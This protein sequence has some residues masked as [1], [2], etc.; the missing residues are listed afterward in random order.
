MLSYLD[1][2]FTGTKE[3][4][5]TDQLVVVRGIVRQYVEEASYD[6]A[7]RVHHGVC[8]GADEEMD[9]IAREEGAFVVMHP[10]TDR[11]LLADLEPRMG[12]DLWLPPEPYLD[13]NRA[14]VRGT[15]VLVATPKNRE[16]PARSTRGSGTWTT[17]KYGL[18]KAEVTGGSYQV[19]VIQPS[20]VEGLVRA[21]SA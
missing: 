10:P 6:T 2:G 1:V 14:I 21:A 11:K 15:S 16:M 9:Q 4:M 13:R 7:V 19:R 17:V 5:T 18:A 20:G 8:V 12:V 3:G